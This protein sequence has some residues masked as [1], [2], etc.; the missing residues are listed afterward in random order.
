M[1]SNYQVSIEV[2]I[3]CLLNGV[4]LDYDNKKTYV[5]LAGFMFKNINRMKARLTN[6]FW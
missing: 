5:I 3:T 2:F 1:M 6:W 4:E